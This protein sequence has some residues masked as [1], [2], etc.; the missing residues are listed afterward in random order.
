[1]DTFYDVVYPWLE[2]KSLMLEIFL[3]TWGK[4][5]IC[6]KEKTTIHAFKNHQYKV[7]NIKEDIYRGNRGSSPHNIG[8]QLN[9]F[10]T[11]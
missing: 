4:Y 9:R 10:C 1:M 3:G 5:Q 2:I 7:Q 6:V 11:F 8:Y